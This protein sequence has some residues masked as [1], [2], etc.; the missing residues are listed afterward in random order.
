MSGVAVVWLT[1]GGIVE[2]V[3]DDETNVVVI[4]FQ[5][6]EAGDPVPELSEAHLRLLQE[7]APSVLDDIAKYE[8]STVRLAS[9]A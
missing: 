4:D 6:V 5:N 7:Y 8:K 1:R 2:Y 9:L 3:S